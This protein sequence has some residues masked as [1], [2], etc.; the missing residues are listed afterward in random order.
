MEVL[1]PMRILG[2]VIELI[3]ACS[4]AEGEQGQRKGRAHDG[5]SIKS[6]IG[7]SWGEA[8]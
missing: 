3:L 1:F 7:K 2:A 8:L 6:F 4:T 5:T